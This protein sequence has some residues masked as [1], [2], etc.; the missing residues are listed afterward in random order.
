MLEFYHPHL[1]AKVVP[2][3]LYSLSITEQ[4]RCGAGVNECN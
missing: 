4:S 1:D 2:R 3:E